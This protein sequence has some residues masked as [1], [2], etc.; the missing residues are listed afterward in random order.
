LSFLGLVGAA[1]Y[2]ILAGKTRKRSPF[3]CGIKILA[4]KLITV[5]RLLYIDTNEVSFVVITLA[6]SSMALIQRRRA[7]RSL[8]AHAGE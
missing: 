6:L 4:P 5:P 8:H 1:T 2:G 3:H 7:R